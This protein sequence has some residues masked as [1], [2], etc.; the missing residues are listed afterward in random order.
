MKKA[1]LILNAILLCELCFAQA[2]QGFN[3]QGVA[4]NAAGDP[5]ASKTIKVRLSI[6]DLTATGTAV[7]A[8]THSPATSANGLFSTTVGAGTV[9][10]GVFAN[11]DWANGSK[12][13]KSEIDINGGNNFVTVATTQMMSVPYALYAQTS[14]KASVRAMGA[15][16]LIFTA[17]R[18]ANGQLMVAFELNSTWKNNIITVMTKSFING[19]LV[20]SSS[21]LSE[22]LFK[23]NSKKLGVLFVSYPKAGD[24]ISLVSIFQTEDGI[25]YKN[26]LNYNIP[27]TKYYL[28][29]DG[30]GYG[31]T[32]VSTSD[33]Q[34]YFNITSASS[35]S[36][37]YSFADGISNINQ[38][39][40]IG[41]DCCD[42]IA[43]GQCQYFDPTRPDQLS[44][45]E[46]INPGATELANGIDDNC[47]GLIDEGFPI[48]TWYRDQDGDGYGG[49]T[50]IQSAIDMSTQGYSLQTGD[51]FDSNAEYLNVAH[52]PWTLLYQSYV[53][54]L[55]N[56]SSAIHPG[57]T[58]VA[59]GVDDN[60]NGLVDEGFA[61]VNWYLDKDDD[62]FGSG[63]P[64]FSTAITNQLFSYTA[65][66]T[67]KTYS[68]NSNDCDDN[69]PIIN[70][71]AQEIPTNGIDDNCN[72]VTDECTSDANCPMGKCVAGQCQID[73]GAV[74][75]CNN[76]IDDDG[77]GL[78][79][80]NCKGIG[81][82]CLDAMD[83]TSGVCF[84]GVCQPPSCT[85]GVKNG[86]E[87]GIDCGGTCPVC[88]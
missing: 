75:I 79:D 3:Y 80:E 47:N 66:A 20:N 30:D 23:D 83:C 16:D 14:G 54:Q 81:S 9:V 6:L 45:A 82:A 76:G 85:D 87:T 43:A 60:C 70:P 51:C 31:S 13:L 10:T 73:P 71:N 48:K 59:N 1:L 4:R 34:K 46:N 39:L 78:V 69:N 15:N 38:L 5:I 56:S 36:I 65:D 12:F 50:S 74:E 33:K 52:D 8:E 24:V 64:A 88:P 2:P 44:T 18:Y 62:D 57:A 22:L 7:Y 40:T 35:T 27:S 21:D 42:D 11:I 86:N 17:D 29:L 58:E 25:I 55:V 63:Q 28:D 68:L 53:S 32:D 67:G 26:E 77:D 41:G 72:G 37:T 49:A 61:R 19:N 84:N